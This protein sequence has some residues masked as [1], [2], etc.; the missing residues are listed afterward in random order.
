MLPPM[1]QSADAETLFEFRFHNR[2]GVD[3]S[4][5]GLHAINLGSK[6]KYEMH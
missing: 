3:L 6:K 2:Y 4:V 5:S 1:R